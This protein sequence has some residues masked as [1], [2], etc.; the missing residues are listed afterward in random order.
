MIQHAVD[1]ERKVKRRMTA[2]AQLAL[3]DTLKELE[4]HVVNSGFHKCLIKPE[5]G[6]V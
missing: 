2:D 1:Q 4:F 5:A 3:L 6:P